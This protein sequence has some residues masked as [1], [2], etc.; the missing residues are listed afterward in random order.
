MSYKYSIYPKSVPYKNT[1]H[2]T[3]QTS[4]PCEEDSKTMESCLDTEPESMNNQLPSVWNK[5]IDYQIIDTAGNKWIDFTSCI[6]VA[7]VGHA[8]SDVVEAINRTVNKGLLNAYYYPTAERAEFT[9]NLLNASGQGFNKVLLL[10]TGSEANEA[11]VKMTM[12]FGSKKNSKK[13]KVL[14]FENSFHGKTMG[15]QMVGGKPKEKKWIAWQHPDI[16]NIPFPYPWILD[17]QSK[18]GK[19]F[20]IDTINQLIETKQLESIEDIAGIIFEPYQGWCAVFLPNDYMQTMR[21][22]ADKYNFLM[23]SDEV[24]SGFGRTGKLFAYEHFGVDVDIV[25]CGKGISSSLPLSAVITREEIIGDNGSFNST[26]GG[27]PVAVSASNASLGYLL[28]HD[29]VN[30]SAQKGKL[31]ETLL[32]EWQ[33]QLPQYIDKIYCKGL[34]ASVFIKSNTSESNEDFVDKLIEK[35][36]YKGLV[37]VRTSSGTLKLGPPLT[38]PESAL[39]EGIEILK[40]SLSELIEENKK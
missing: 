10:S 6:F 29:L 3:I 37:S 11:A 13:R 31:L 9:R 34:L 5:A 38:I 19:Q 24:Q 30:Q 28:K 25:V 4:I 14:S 26:H 23:I 39:I 2:V 1:D 40:E 8:N 36:F 21:E 33:K 18:S 12:I 7:N 16:I 22:F 20:F 32:S 27:N 17:Q 35:A 15:S